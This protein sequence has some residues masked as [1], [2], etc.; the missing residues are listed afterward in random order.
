MREP[1]DPAQ[2]A[3]VDGSNQIAEALCTHAKDGL[4]QPSTIKS[5]ICVSSVIVPVDPQ[6]SS[7]S[8]TPCGPYRA[9]SH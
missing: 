5:V 4:D 3:S 9:V 7:N 1:L 8:E 2:V 6:A